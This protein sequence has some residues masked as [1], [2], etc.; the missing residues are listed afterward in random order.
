MIAPILLENERSGG[1]LLLASVK[2]P[3][4]A[5]ADREILEAWAHHLGR[6]VN[7]WPDITPP[8]EIEMVKGELRVAPEELAEVSAVESR[9]SM[10][11]I[12]TL[13]SQLMKMHEGSRPFGATT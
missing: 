3:N 1:L 12:G 13:T 4:W 10:V 2:R 8:E 11:R 7:S 9:T 6:K 5:P